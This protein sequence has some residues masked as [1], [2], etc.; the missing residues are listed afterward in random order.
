MRKSLAFSLLLGA[1]L[2]LP[3]LAS[4][5]SCTDVT[6]FPMYISCAGAFGGNI[7]D[8]NNLSGELTQLSNLFGS[9]YTYVGQTGDTNFGPFANDPSGSASGTLT[10]DTSLSGLFVVGI[11]A[12]DNYSFYQYDGGVTGISSVTFNTG[13]TAVNNS[14][15][16]QELSH[17]TLYVSTSTGVNITATPEPSTYALMGAGLLAMGF[18]ARKRRKA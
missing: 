9:T 1:S 16:P 10:F 12:S 11:K 15:E 3:K 7:G 8:G 6:T 18:V 4:A 13:G 14:E 5:Q 17:A 2:M